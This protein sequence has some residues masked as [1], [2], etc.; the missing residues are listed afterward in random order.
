MIAKE[1]A[2]ETPRQVSKKYAD[3][4]PGPGILKIKK[5]SYESS[6]EAKSTKQSFMSSGDKINSLSKDCRDVSG[7]GEEKIIKVTATIILPTT[8]TA[9]NT[10]KTFATTTTQV[11]TSDCFNTIVSNGS[12]VALA[13][14]NSTSVASSFGLTLIPINTRAAAKPLVPT[15]LVSTLT[16]TKTSSTVFGNTNAAIISPNNIMP[17]N[18][19]NQGHNATMK[20]LNYTLTAATKP[21]I[22]STKVTTLDSN[23]VTLSNNR[24]TRATSAAS[25]AQSATHTTNNLNLLHGDNSKLKTKPARTELS[26]A[27]AKLIEDTPVNQVIVEAATTVNAYISSIT[28]P[29]TNS[30]YIN[31]MQNSKAITP[32][33]FTNVTNLNPAIARAATTSTIKPSGASN[34]NQKTEKTCSDTSQLFETATRADTSSMTSSLS[35]ASR[36]YPSSKSKAAAEQVLATNLK[37]QKATK[38]AFNS[39]ATP[40]AFTT[41]T[42]SKPQTTFAVKEISTKPIATA[43]AANKTTVTS[44]TSNIHNAVTTIGTVTFAK[45]TETIMPNSVSRK[46]SITGT[47]TATT[48]TAAKQQDTCTD[49][50]NNLTTNIAATVATTT[51]K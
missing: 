43:L 33:L 40:T 17:A 24:S 8:K 38:S 35:S 19:G 41:A 2:F 31:L 15:K 34:E 45:G 26:H 1:A 51:S 39:K 27:A 46:S 37:I 47:T 48:N 18:Y 50:L 6:S 7:T 49:I 12:E 36:T 25:S 23:S 28:T 3:Q 10:L 4:R 22:A 42:T 32:A 44:V 14:I 30:K 20:T 29:S 5:N 11:T 21:P 13:L 16:T 9:A